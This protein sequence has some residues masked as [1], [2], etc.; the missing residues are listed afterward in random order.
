MMD[1][2]T[3]L[4]RTAK[5]NVQLKIAEITDERKAQLIAEYYDPDNCL[6][7]TTSQK[8]L[9]GNWLNNATRMLLKGATE[10]EINR[11]VEHIVVILHAVKRQLNVQKSYVDHNLLDLTRKYFG[12]YKQVKLEDGEIVYEKVVD[13]PLWKR[14]Q[15]KEEHERKNQHRKEMQ[16]K[17]QNMLD[18]G[19]TYEYIAEELMI[20]E[21]T[22]RNIMKYHD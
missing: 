11:V 16:E 22:A 18:S 8:V 2:K 13:D 20:S 17:I 3:M 6:K 21:S 5:A 1:H 10:E 15:R 7:S 14:K 19:C 9:I 4:N 12:V